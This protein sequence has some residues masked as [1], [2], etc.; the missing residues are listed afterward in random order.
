[1]V[2]PFG[3]RIDGQV[4]PTCNFAIIQNNLL[5][6]K[7]RYHN[8][9]TKVVKTIK[10]TNFLIRKLNFF[11]RVINFANSLMVSPKE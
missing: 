4:A 8:G 10:Y 6:C 2:G 9:S 11:F 5:L 7:R 3:G 1:M